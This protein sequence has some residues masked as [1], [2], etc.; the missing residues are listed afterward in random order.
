MCKSDTKWG[1]RLVRAFSNKNIR[2]RYKSFFESNPFDRV[3]ITAWP[4]SICIWLYRILSYSDCWLLC[5]KEMNVLCGISIFAAS[6][7]ESHCSESEC[8]Q[9]CTTYITNWK[10]SNEHN[11]RT[12]SAHLCTAVDPIFFLDFP[13]HKRIPNCAADSWQN[14]RNPNISYMILYFWC[15]LQWSARLMYEFQL[16]GIV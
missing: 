13:V 5:I 9:K 1:E 14:N 7:M 4:Q 6:A 12:I 16:F 3:T 11:K 8:F 2:N 10:L 15:T